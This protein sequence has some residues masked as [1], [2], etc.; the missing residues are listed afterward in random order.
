VVN[1]TPRSLYPRERPSTDCTGARVGP[2]VGVD[3]CGNVA[4][5]GIRS[6]Y[7]P[8]RS[9]SQHLRPLNLFFALF[10]ISVLAKP[11]QISD[12]CHL[13]CVCQAVPMSEPLSHCKTY[14]IA[15]CTGRT[16]CTRSP[17]FAMHRNIFVTCQVPAH[18][19]ASLQ[20]D[21]APPHPRRQKV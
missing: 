2:R 11:L 18:C 21:S 12:L 4:C 6:P 13:C 3:G 7:R 8:A 19:F 10:R 5:T 14:A 17:H 1:A 16:K 15:L 20:L 9:D